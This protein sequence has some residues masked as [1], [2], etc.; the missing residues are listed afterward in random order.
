[1]L[2]IFLSEDDSVILIGFRIMLL[3]MGHKIV[4]EASDGEA[5][6]QGI[7]E[8][9]PELVIMDI[10]MPKLDGITVLERLSAEGIS[11]PCIMV[12]G[13]RDEKL[14][15]RAMAAGVLGYMQKP[16]D[17]YELHTAIGLAMKHYGYVEELKTEA[18]ESKREAEEAKKAL[19]DR[20]VVERAKGILMDSLG[21][22][23]SDAMKAIQK[24]SRES[25]KKLVDAARE[26]ITA[27]SLL[28]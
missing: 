22:K 4:G 26:I 20:K 27:S 17:E 11:V 18:R 13:Y 1:M 28:S 5:A 21:I 25:N 2:R 16:I 7:R 6:I 14:V 8:T 23:E 9:K 15:E 10:N 24:K 19:A 3:N 12:T